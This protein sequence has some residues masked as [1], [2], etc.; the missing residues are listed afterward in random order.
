VDL[1]FFAVR[2]VLSLAPVGLIPRGVTKAQALDG[3]E[4]REDF[5]VGGPVEEM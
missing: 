5:F 2:R 1:R 3:L 4:N